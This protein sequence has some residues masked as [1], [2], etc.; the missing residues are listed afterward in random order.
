MLNICQ[1]IFQWSPP[2]TLHIHYFQ[3]HYSPLMPWYT[4]PI[5]CYMTLIS[6]HTTR[7]LPSNILH[8][9]ILWHTACPLSSDTLHVPYPWHTTCPLSHATLH[10]PYPMIYY[11]PC[12]PWH[13]ICPLSPDTLHGPYPMTYYT[14]CIPWHTIWSIS[15]DL[16]SWT[17]YVWLNGPEYLMATTYLFGKV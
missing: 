11:M 6:W 13:T 3:R 9:L 2:D 5:T 10:G 14:A 7:P 12:I 8:S 17:R 1:N 16:Q 4:T 15:H